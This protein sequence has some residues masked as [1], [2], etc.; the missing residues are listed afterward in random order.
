M[1]TTSAGTTFAV[2]AFLPAAYTEAGFAAL[3]YTQIR[4]IKLIGDIVR[5]Y[6][7]TKRDVIGEEVPY[8]QRTGRAAVSA[9]VEVIR[10]TDAGQAVLL[11]AFSALWSYSFR[12]TR[13]DGSVMYFTAKP[14]D[15][16]SGGFSPS[17][18]ADNRC[19]LQIDSEVIG[20]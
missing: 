15:W 19:T 20:D 12:L 17:S 4:G 8:N 7:T 13:R 1:V 2:A 3:T 11:A 10:I 18:I 6:E 5:Q 16:S 14:S 9:D